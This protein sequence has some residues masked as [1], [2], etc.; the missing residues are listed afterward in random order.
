[1]GVLSVT[2]S[3]RCQSPA[4]PRVTSQGVWIDGRHAQEVLLFPGVGLTRYEALIGPLTGGR[5]EME[6]RP[7]EFWAPAPCLSAQRL[8]TAVIEAGAAHHDLY[9]HAPVLELRADT[10]GEQ[11]DVPLYAYAEQARQGAEHDLALHGRVQQRGRRHAHPRA[12][13]AVGPDDGHRAGLRGHAVGG[14]DHARGVPGPGPRGSSVHRPA[15][16]RGSGAARRHDEQHG[17][18][19][20]PRPRGGPARARRRRPVPCHP[21]VDDGRA[22]VGLSR[23]GERAGVRGARRRECAARRGMAETGA[24]PALARVLRGEPPPGPHRRRGV[25]EGPERDAVLVALRQDA[26]RNRP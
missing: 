15:P 21:G 8:D 9:R 5:H 24:R 12:V 13:R 3:D 18:R 10:I 14:P 7:S 1:M 19:S 16:G 6:L 22:A 26:A 2:V 23:H 11:T 4:S 17:D 25:G 20:R